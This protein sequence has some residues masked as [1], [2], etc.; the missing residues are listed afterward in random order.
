MVVDWPEA[1]RSAKRPRLSQST[2]QPAPELKSKKL[3]LY[4]TAQE[5]DILVKW[6]GTA[7]WTYNECLRAMKVEKVPKSKKLL[8]ARAINNEAIETLKKPWLEVT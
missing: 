4:P 1:G 6:I 5:R 3:R 7:F 2:K 8:R